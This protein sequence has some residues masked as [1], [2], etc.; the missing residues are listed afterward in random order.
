[1]YGADG[2]A[3]VGIRISQGKLFDNRSEFASAPQ[4]KISWEASTDAGTSVRVYTALT[5]SNTTT[6]TESEFIEAVNGGY[7]SN[8]VTGSDIRGKYL[9]VM[10]KLETD[11]MTKT[12]SLD[13]LTIDY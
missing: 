6:P 11:D 12:P 9:W 3:N 2:Y 8:I 4:F 5:D 1:M 13:W 10:E 7:I